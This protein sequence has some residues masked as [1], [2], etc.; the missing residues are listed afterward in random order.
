MLNCAAVVLGDTWYKY[1]P[2]DSHPNDELSCCH[3]NWP[4]LA[5]SMIHATVPLDRIWECARK[6]VARDVGLE[7]KC[8]FMTQLL[9]REQIALLAIDKVRR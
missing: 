4:G 8:T 1:T 5:A 9:D 7:N 6:I 3:E 2:V